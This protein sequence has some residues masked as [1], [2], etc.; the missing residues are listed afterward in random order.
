[1]TGDAD[2]RWLTARPIAHRGL[3]D[4]SRGVVEN[5][6][7]AAR[8]A[9]RAGFAIEC[10]VQE[11]VDGE[12]VVFHDERLERLTSGSGRLDARSRA[13][14]ESL[15]LLEGD[16][17][18]P[19]LSD[20][21]ATV[22]GAVPIVVEVKSRFDGDLSL[23]RRVGEIAA[24]YRG[25]IAIE[26][27]DPDVIAELRAGRFAGSRVPLGVVSQA[28][29]EDWSWLST[30]QRVEMTQ[31]LHYPRTRLDFLSWRVGDLPQA[32]PFLCREALRLPVTTWTVRSKD[33]AEAASAWSDQIVFEG[34]SP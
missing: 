12:V 13:E 3:H 31:F 4:H 6:L 25:Q 21:L 9:V 24:A 11:T 26:S 1:V 32:I 33:Q 15:V 7:S 5:S 30:S 2:F 17:G 14:L 28:S 20:L 8:A 27:F 10:D 23:A 34:F 29:Y 22:G 16:D 18:I 19:S